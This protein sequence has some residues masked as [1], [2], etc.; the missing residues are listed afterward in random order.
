MDNPRTHCQQLNRDQLLSLNRT[1]QCISL[2]ADAEIDY[3][4][5]LRRGNSDSGT[6]ESWATSDNTQRSTDRYR[7]RHQASV[8]ASANP[9]GVTATISSTPVAQPATLFA[10]TDVFAT[11]ADL[12]DMQQQIDAIETV[13]SLPG[14]R[15]LISQRNGVSDTGPQTGTRGLL[16][17]Y[18][19]HLT[20][21]GP[22]LIEVNTNAG[23]AFIM[24][25]MLSGIGQRVSPCNED[26]LDNP[27]RIE[28][29]LTDMFTREWQRA[30]RN[31]RPA[32][33]AIVDSQPEQ[34]FLYTDML[35]AKAM[36]EK[37]NIKTVICAPESLTH[38]NGKLYCEDLQIDFVYNRCTDFYFNETATRTLRHALLTNSAV[39][40]PAP[41]HHALFADK[42][43]LAIWQ[44][45]RQMKH[46]AAP[47]KKTAAL[48]R[49]PATRPVDNCD[50][51]TLW[52]HRKKLFFKPSAGYGS[53]A[54]YRGDKLTRKVWQSI[55]Q[56]GYIAQNLEPPALRL[57]GEGDDI[58][59]MKFDVR[60]Y[61]YNGTR[62]LSAA[63]V[64]QGQTTNFRTPGGGFAPVVYLD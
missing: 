30:G 62:L 49:I 35:L 27:D 52:S 43:N 16:M 41:L 51:D 47:A 6:A 1:C 12:R 44:D 31:G 22:R 18:D 34:Q 23:G 38:A 29:A 56:G 55:L 57:V 28:P 2:P 54:A 19:F 32:T 26:V 3:F 15:Q 4:A 5:D 21:Q 33:V 7:I 53:K 25:A 11:M 45:P 9:S 59:L 60:I 42:R 39:I 37:S 48:E 40:S 50:A 61:T 10:R 63:R 14:Y 17:G 24:H 20:D 13:A 58:T 8:V 36:L 46:L 64:Y